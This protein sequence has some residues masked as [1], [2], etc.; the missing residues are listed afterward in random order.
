MLYNFKRRFNSNKGLIQH[1]N[2][3]RKNSAS[4]IIN[5]ARIDE[6]NKK[7]ENV[8][9]DKNKPEKFCRNVVLGSKRSTRSL[10]EY[11]LLLQ[12]SYKPT[13]TTGKKFLD[14]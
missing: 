12:K 6:P 13:G 11:S 3:C 8:L 14:F 10:L 2:N 5:N 4:V 1:L 9:I 7:L